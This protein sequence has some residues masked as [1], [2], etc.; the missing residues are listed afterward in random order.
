MNSLRQELDEVKN[1]IN[2]HRIILYTMFVLLVI[3]SISVVVTLKMVFPSSI[4]NT[5]PKAQTIGLPTLAVPASTAKTEPAVPLKK[6]Y[7]NPFDDK[8]QYVN[9]FTQNKNPFDSLK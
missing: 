4:N 5:L 8:T 9:P 3:L 6:D 7:Q 1:Y 2:H